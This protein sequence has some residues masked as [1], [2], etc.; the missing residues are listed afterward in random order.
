VIAG[1][2]CGF[3]TSAGSGRVEKGIVWEKLK[4]MREGAEMVS[5]TFAW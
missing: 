4:S 1:T 5:Q 3:E 2:D